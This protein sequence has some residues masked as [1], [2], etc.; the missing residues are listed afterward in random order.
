MAEYKKLGKYICSGDIIGGRRV[1]SGYR[2]Q[3]DG[4]HGFY[5]ATMDDG[6][7]ERFPLYSYLVTQDDH[8][9]VIHAPVAPAV[10]E[11]QTMST[12]EKDRIVSL[13]MRK[14]LGLDTAWALERNQRRAA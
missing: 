8:P 6:S 2:Y 9:A 10:V 11:R 1:V 13:R 4:S 3:D 7:V 12:R 5:V 14:G